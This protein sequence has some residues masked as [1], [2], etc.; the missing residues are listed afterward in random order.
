MTIRWA[1]LLAVL[2]ASALHAQI[3]DFSDHDNSHKYGVT[4]LSADDVPTYEVWAQHAESEEFIITVYEDITIGDNYNA[5][6]RT[7]GTD[8]FLDWY[9]VYQMIV[10]NKRTGEKSE[11]L[12]LLGAA[13][14]YHDLNALT[15]TPTINDLEILRRYRPAIAFTP[16]ASD[17]G[18]PTEAVVAIPQ[19]EADGYLDIYAVFLQYDAG[20]GTFIESATR[21]SVNVSES[22][23]D[24]ATDT[25]DSTSPSIAILDDGSGT[26]DFIVTWIDNAATGTIGGLAD[27]PGLQGS[28][29]L[30]ARRFVQKYTLPFGAGASAGGAAVNVSDSG[31]AVDDAVELDAKIVISDDLD[32]AWIGFVSEGDSGAPVGGI[33]SNGPTGN[34]SDVYV[35]R[36]DISSLITATGTTTNVTTSNGHNYYFDLVLN[37]ALEQVGVVFN[38][39]TASGAV[40]GNTLISAKTSLPAPDLLPNLQRD[41]FIRTFDVAGGQFS[42]TQACFRVTFDDH[43]Q[44]IVHAASADVLGFYV[45]WSQNNKDTTN[46]AWLGDIESYTQ[47]IDTTGA[48]LAAVGTADNTPS[49]E[50]GSAVDPFEYIFD[51]SS[52]VEFSS[53]A[54]KDVA[55]SYFVASDGD[56]EGLRP[57]QPDIQGLASDLY[58][59]IGD[60]EGSGTGVVSIPAVFVNEGRPIDPINAPES[61]VVE[62]Q[63]SNNSFSEI[64]SLENCTI[65]APDGF[66][67]NGDISPDP[68]SGVDIPPAA[69]QSFTVSFYVTAEQLT[70]GTQYFIVQVYG[71]AGSVE[72]GDTGAGSVVVT[73]TTGSITG[74]EM[75]IEFTKLSGGAPN[76]AEGVDTELSCRV[77]INNVSGT[78]DLT[79]LDF[80]GIIGGGFSPASLA[81]AEFSPDPD[82]ATVASG[83]IGVF[84]AVITATS[85]VKEGEFYPAIAASMN[86][87]TGSGIIT[88][89][90][91]VPIIVSSGNSDDDEETSASD[92]F[93]TRTPNK[94]LGCSVSGSGYLR[95]G[96]LALL[97]VL[98]FAGLILCRRRRQSQ[99]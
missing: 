88:A 59:A 8:G 90:P 58:L 6:A 92:F 19:V 73:G 98:A 10:Y 4:N 41:A 27:P 24:V 26:G 78:D 49:L 5:G 97:G 34:T 99:S 76:I 84:T 60:A 51:M 14:V 61:V 91:L 48:A 83:E 80:D 69:D 30:Y 74:V 37:E 36:Y 13:P 87:G 52:V 47:L 94:V 12:A 54:I 95:N 17:P 63:I 93:G 72:V 21:S 77:V 38:D 46:N 44:R 25:G 66:S 1:G 2:L 11:P 75:S 81:F 7:G 39:N 31:D 79:N 3:A 86:Q 82:T 42:S 22:D 71:T 40:G 70:P 20:S 45:G 89:V 96:T 9:I 33:A 18:N 57:G 85:N 29:D 50:S 67:Q 28:T 43:D 62:F 55:I 35:R 64:L 65:T 56:Q 68:N 53:A 16:L 15:L 32:V 23:G